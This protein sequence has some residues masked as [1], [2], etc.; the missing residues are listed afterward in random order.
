MNNLSC[1]LS[2]NEV[3]ACNFCG[4]FSIK[5]YFLVRKRGVGADRRH[6]AYLFEQYDLILL[7][8]DAL[9]LYGASECR[10]HDNK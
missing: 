5:F 4:V 2:N 3:L 7:K 9:V 8:T 10:S 1:R 6:E